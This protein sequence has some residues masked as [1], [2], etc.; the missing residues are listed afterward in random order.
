[1]KAAVVIF[2]GSNCDVDMIHALEDVLGCQVA[3]V[4]HKDTSLQGADLV[5][6][7]GG[8]S[9]GDYLRGGALASFS[10]IMEAVIA[11]AQAG[12]LLMGVCN[13]FQVLTES[14]LLPGCLMRNRTLQFR[15]QDVYLTVENNQTVFTSLYRSNQ[16]LR[17][18]IAHGEGCYYASEA[19]LR[20]LEDSGRVVFRYSNAGGE[21]TPEA[22]P[23]GSSRA[24]AGIVNAA[25]NVLGMMPHPER[26][27]EELVGGSDGRWLFHGILKAWKERVI[28]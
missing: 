2:P 10:P 17:L 25:G 1:M 6:L 8:F 24:I 20:E 11:H 13:G 4:W 12:K 26:Y 28:S 27:C 7:P 19:E 18:P 23:N 9:Y 3:Q 5:A 15:C 21:Y 22:N 16:V 14:G